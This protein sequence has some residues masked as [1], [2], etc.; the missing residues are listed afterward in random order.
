MSL[1]AFATGSME[2]MPASARS[3]ARGLGDV[4]TN[5]PGQANRGANKRCV[6]HKSSMFRARA[7]ELSPHVPMSPHVDIQCGACACR[8]ST[9]HLSAIDDSVPDRKLLDL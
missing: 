8:S 2:K 6:A 4:G 1:A 9:R 5:N 7:P 3:V